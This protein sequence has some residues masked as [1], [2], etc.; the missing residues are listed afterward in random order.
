[1]CSYVT[2]KA[3]PQNRLQATLPR[4]FPDAPSFLFSSPPPSLSLSLCVT[5]EAN[6]TPVH[7]QSVKKSKEE[8][9]TEK[10]KARSR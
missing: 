2:V 3:K 8:E 9:N 5:E 6:H 4:W 7:S 1:M 10:K